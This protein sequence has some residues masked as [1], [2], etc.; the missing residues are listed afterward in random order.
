MIIFSKIDVTMYDFMSIIDNTI[1][2]L[3][4]ECEFEFQTIIMIGLLS[5]FIVFLLFSMNNNEKGFEHP[6]LS[7]IFFIL[8][9][10][11]PGINVYFAALWTCTIDKVS[12]RFFSFVFFLSL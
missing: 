7:V 10:E 6:I 12:L 9:K 4:F 2:R 11:N 1:D 3:E 5:F 8:V